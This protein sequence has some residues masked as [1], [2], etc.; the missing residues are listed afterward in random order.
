ML[1]ELFTSEGC[2]SCPPADELLM[3]LDADQPVPGVLVIPLSEHVEYWNGQWHDPFSSPVFTDRQRQYQ[4]SLATPALYTPQMVVDGQMQLIGSRQQLAYEVIAK[5][6]TRRRSTLSL[7]RVESSDGGRVLVDI[8]VSDMAQLAPAHDADLW[9]AIT[10][11]GLETE[12]H[13]GE[14]AFRR[15]RH[16]GVVRKLQQVKPFAVPFPDHVSATAVIEVDPTWSVE[17]LRAVA[18]LQERSSRRVLG[19]TQRRL[20]APR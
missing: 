15:L 9:V 8:T 20:N 13:R 10:E 11:D 5:A 4:Q 12:V 18:F 16:G 2:L 19:A 14:N 17:R 6:V 3:R 7:T 1:V